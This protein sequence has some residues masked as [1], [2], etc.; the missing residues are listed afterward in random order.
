MVTRFD[1]IYFKTEGVFQQKNIFNIYCPPY[2]TQWC[3]VKKVQQLVPLVP[4][5]VSLKMTP[6]G[7]NI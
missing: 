3:K 4:Y 5:F 6:W 2:T 1:A 7:R